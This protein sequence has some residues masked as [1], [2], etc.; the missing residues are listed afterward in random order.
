MYTGFYNIMCFTY[1]DAVS[2]PLPARTVAP[3]SRARSWGVLAEKEGS[4]AWSVYNTVDGGGVR[5]GYR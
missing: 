2:S 4:G 3:G 5:P 1:L